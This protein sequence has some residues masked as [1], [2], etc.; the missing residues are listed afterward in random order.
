MKLNWIFLFIIVIVC[1]GWGFNQKKAN[2]YRQVKCSYI[3]SYN[4]IQILAGGKHFTTLIYNTTFHLP[5]NTVLTRPIL[6]PVYS[7]SQIRMQRQFSLKMVKGESRDEPHQVG[8]FFGYGS[9]NEVNG[10]SF[11]AY[12]PEGD[13]TRVEQE[14]VTE[15]KEKHGDVIVGTRNH[16]IGSNG[17]LVLI[18]DRT[19]KFSANKSQRAIDFTFDLKAPDQKVVFKDTKEGMFAI[20]VAD[21]LAESSHGKPNPPLLE[22][23]TGKYLNSEGDTTSQNVWGKRAKWVRLEG[24]HKGKTVGIIIMNHPSSVNYPTFWHARDYGLFAAD[25][26]GQ[27][28]FQKA[29]GVVPQLLNYTI[30]AGDSAL[31]KFKMIIYEGHRTAA[32]INKDFQEYRSSK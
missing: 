27:S 15:L 3:R 11:W 23:H 13:Q 5:R 10:N 4:Q 31:F 25:P 18:E 29:Q 12:H 17:S 21:W 24:H 9:N 28:V 26:L 6:Y 14:A 16:W 19:M 20:R 8:I 7:P 32:Q 1:A 30:P 2:G 22:K